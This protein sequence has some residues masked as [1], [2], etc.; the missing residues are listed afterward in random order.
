[1]K[2]SFPG[3]FFLGQRIGRRGGFLVRQRINLPGGIDMTQQGL[4]AAAQVKSW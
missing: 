1:M 4:F 3:G 2:Q